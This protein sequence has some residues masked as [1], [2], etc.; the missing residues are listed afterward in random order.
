MADPS[1][2]AEQAALLSALYQAERADTSAMFTNALALFGSAIAYVA[3]VLGFVA[4]GTTVNGVMLAFAPV[5]ACGLIAY[6][7]L[8]VG[9]NSARAASAQ[10]LETKIR[11][12]WD[13]R[14]ILACWQNYLEIERAGH[15]S[16]LGW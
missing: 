6:H 14:A 4:S 2:D 11:L 15:C 13:P 16:W 12:A 5:P 7:Q 3:V 8:M 1:I 9:M 10:Q